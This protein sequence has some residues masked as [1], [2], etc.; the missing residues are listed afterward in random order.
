MD[1]FEKAYLTIINEA[2]SID[3]NSTAEEIKKY[4][5][6]KTIVKRSMNASSKEKT[7]EK[8]KIREVRLNPKN[9]QVMLIFDEGQPMF[10]KD[11]KDLKKHEEEPQLE[12]KKGVIVTKINGCKSYEDWCFNSN[13]VKW[14]DFLKKIDESDK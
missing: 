11:W 7:E 10:F 4:F 13:A 12:V 14:A 5:A 8:H 3:D 1:K 2:A 9:K 6:G